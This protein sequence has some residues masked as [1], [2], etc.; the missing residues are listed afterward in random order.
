MSIVDI[1][2]PSECRQK[3]RLGAY[4]SGCSD[5]RRKALTEALLSWQQFQPE[6]PLPAVP[7]QVREFVRALSQSGRSGKPLKPQTIRFMLRQISHLHVHV[8]EVEDPAKHMLVSSEM[9]A[10][11]RERGSRAH[12]TAPLRLKGNVADIINDDPLPGSILAMLRA[13]E[14]DNSAWALR[15]RVVLGLG[16]DTG[17]GRAEYV[18]LNVGDIV[19]MPDDSGTAAFRRSRSDRDLDEAPRYVSPDTM[20]FIREWLRWREKAAPGSA[21]PDKPVLV[22]IDQKGRPGGRL[23]V[24][25]Y[26]DVL[27][28]IIRRVGSSTH[29]SGNSFQAGLKIDLMAIG[30][31]KIGIA[32]AL[33]FKE[34]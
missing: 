19:C 31:T 25:G 8:F 14:G 10:L 1:I 15:T 16:A 5:S 32:N 21:A 22:R 18:A 11:F 29:V 30:T 6:S 4:L 27:K 13:L 12:A 7:Q 33:G 26:V 2:F 24:E 23:S 3:Q 34:L 17:R 20:T 28:D 9:K